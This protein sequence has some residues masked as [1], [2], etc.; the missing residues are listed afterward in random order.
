MGNRKFLN[1]KCQETIRE[2]PL[3]SDISADLF[4]VTAS[5]EEVALLFGERQP[6]GHEEVVARLT[7]RV[8]ISPFVAKRLLFALQD[9]IR[10]YESKFGSLNKNTVTGTDRHIKRPPLSLPHFKSELAARWIGR[11]FEQLKSLDLPVG[12]ERSF[13]ISEKK[14]SSNRFLLAF[15]P[16]NI[17]ENPYAAISG[18]CDRMDMP[19][20]FLKAFNQELSEATMIGFGIEE[21]ES[22]CV[23]KAYL[24]FRNRYEEAI[25]R[26]PRP[27]DPY[28]SHLGFKWNAADNAKGALANYMCYPGFT[29][30]EML[31]RIAEAFYPSPS[32]KSFEIIESIL[33]LASKKVGQDKFL[34]LEVNELGNPRSSFD[35]N[36]YGANLRLEELQPYFLDECRHYSIPED[37]FSG[38]YDSVKTSTLGHIAGGRDRK[39]RD[40]L[41]VYFGE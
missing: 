27:S 16:K 4:K 5:R 12:L 35:I 19:G 7:K 39:G 11:L 24:E 38:F 10:N 22:T 3:P 8:L 28:V 41:T 6:S 17:A 34:Y 2:K 18:I 14:L 33:V 23:V 26:N 25:R 9:A 36:L 1:V 40:F 29:A 21:E 31:E 13:K 15:E 30:G 20:E 37:E 32:R